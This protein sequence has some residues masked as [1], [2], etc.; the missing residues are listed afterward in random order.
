MA[1]SRPSLGLSPAAARAA[2]LGARRPAARP[3]GR[4]TPPLDTLAPPGWSGGST[5]GTHGGNS[6]SRSAR[7]GAR[8]IGFVVWVLTAS[9]PFQ[10]RAG[11]SVWTETPR[12]GM[13]VSSMSEA[14]AGSLLVEYFKAFL[15]D[16]DLDAF[17]NRVAVRYNE[18][19]LCRL[20]TISPD[21]A[22]RRAAVLSLGILGSFEQSNAALARALRDDDLAVRS[23]AE[24]ALWAVWFRADTPEHNQVLSQVRLAINDEQL[25]QAEVLVTRLI[26][27]APNF[28]E[29][30]NQRA[31]IYFHQGRFADSV[32][33][34][35]SVLARN[36]Y[37]FGAIS[38]MAQ[39]LLRLRRP[40]DALKTLRRALKLQPHHSSL[41]D[42]I[43][44]LEMEIE[45][46]GPR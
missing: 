41:R 21:L 42:S 24:D 26:S 35:Q 40:Q 43:R 29:A 46:D 27:E 7:I 36:P 30:Y 8:G 1:G 5:A 10:T 39:C 31:I 34:C 38:G 32:R 12:L 2:R 4:Q 28:A 15:R 25:D 18:G 17:R 22:A 33:E 16:R 11:V 37:H 6:S 23:M 44:I 20:L 13:G 3:W 45:S 19:T 9:L 14:H